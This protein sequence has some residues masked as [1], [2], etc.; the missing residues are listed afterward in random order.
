MA[1]CPGFHSWNFTGYQVYTCSNSWTPWG[2]N[3]LPAYN[4]CKCKTIDATVSHTCNDWIQ[5]PFV[6]SM[7]DASTRSFKLLFPANAWYSIQQ[8]FPSTDHVFTRSLMILCITDRSKT[9]CF[10]VG[11]MLSYNDMHLCHC[12]YLIIV[13]EKP[14]YQSQHVNAKEK[15]WSSMINRCQWMARRPIFF[16]LRNF[17]G[18]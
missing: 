12:I 16:H 10:E 6:Q 11:F 4:F 8:P 18:Y 14:L 1:R 15:N 5:S 17:T 9:N 2:L 13:I 7:S 3:F